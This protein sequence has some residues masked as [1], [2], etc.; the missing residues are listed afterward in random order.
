MNNNNNINFQKLDTNYI[1]YKKQLLNVI[2]KEC[3]STQRY[4]DSFKDVYTGWKPGIYSNLDYMLKYGNNLQTQTDLMNRSHKQRNQNNQNDQNK[5]SNLSNLYKQYNHSNQSNHKNV[6][7]K[8]TILNKSN[9]SN[10]SKEISKNTDT[11]Q[12]NINASI[13]SYSNASDNITNSTCDIYLNKGLFLCKN[14]KET[15]KLKYDE[16]QKCDKNFNENDYN[17]M[18]VTQK[19][20]TYKLCQSKVTNKICTINKRS[21]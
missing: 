9:Q 7:N 20:N 13:N 14:E 16:I 5:H 15:C 8:S 1:E 6:S 3:N 18:D 11:N 17:C 12:I 10:I 4:L 19:S 21:L 2:E